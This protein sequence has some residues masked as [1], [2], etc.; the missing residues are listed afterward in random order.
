VSS[1]C[2]VIV[3]DGSSGEHC[4]GALAEGGLSVALVERELVGGECS[5]GVCIP[6]K[7]LLRPESRARRERRGGDSA[8]R[9]RGRPRLARPHGSN[10]LVSPAMSAKVWRTS[11]P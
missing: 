3:I 6:C 2:D 9:H 4:A 5:Y 7:T 8:G 11:C 10:L 1:G